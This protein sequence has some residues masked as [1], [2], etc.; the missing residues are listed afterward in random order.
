M[1]SISKLFSIAFLL[2]FGTNYVNLNAES[3]DVK[4][5]EPT[6]CSQCLP[7]FANEINN[8]CTT[9][10]EKTVKECVD[11]ATKKFNRC[12]RKLCKK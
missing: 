7:R 8:V 5:T 3:T 2:A 11:E 6:S 10:K 1:K 9:D 12:Y 4:T